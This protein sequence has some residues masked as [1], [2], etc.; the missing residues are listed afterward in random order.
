MAVN[1]SMKFRT[2]E[3]VEENVAEGF[4][5]FD[6]IDTLIYTP[7]PGDDGKQLK[8]VYSHEAYF[9]DDYDNNVNQAA[10]NITVQGKRDETHRK[11]F[12]LSNISKDR[13]EF[14][15][16]QTSCRWLHLPDYELDETL[17]RN[18]ESNELKN[19]ENIFL[20]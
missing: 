15:A 19:P 12:V 17:L 2:E 1:D 14:I 8:C 6:V 18:K 9:Q 5:S 16:S 4:Q 13:W 11:L 20:V 10:C 3:V 7:T